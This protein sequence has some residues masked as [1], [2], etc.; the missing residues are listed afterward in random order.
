MGGNSPQTS[1][2]MS[3]I[4]SKP[5]LT[6]PDVMIK[7]RQIHNQRRVKLIFTR[8][9]LSQEMSAQALQAAPDTKLV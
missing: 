3:A 5:R 8:A 2:K 4:L 6:F 1:L 9:P 7:T